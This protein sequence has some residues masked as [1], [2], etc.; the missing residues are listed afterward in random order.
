VACDALFTLFRL[1]VTS[2]RRA[3]V[4]VPCP[5][6]TAANGDPDY[7]ELEAAATALPPAAEVARWDCGG[8]NGVGAA[9]V[10]LA[11]WIVHSA[12]SLRPRVV[13]DDDPARLSIPA[14]AAGRSM[15]Q[16]VLTGVGAAGPPPG[17]SKAPSSIV[18]FHGTAAESMHSVLRNGL[19]C[20]SGSGLMRTGDVFGKGVYLSTDQGVAMSFAAPANVTHWASLKSDDADADADAAAVAVSTASR[21]GGSVAFVA[22]CEVSLSAKVQKAREQFRGKARSGDQ[23]TYLVVEDESDVRVRSILIVGDRDP[24]AISASASSSS[25]SSSSSATSA[26]L[27]ASASASASASGPPATG[28]PGAPLT[29]PQP[30]QTAQR[31]PQQQPGTGRGKR[32]FAWG[33]ALYLVLMLGLSLSRSVTVMRQWRRFRAQVLHM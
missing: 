11:A 25:S 24:A 15:T 6:W 31:A 4:C 14:S 3:T 16:I 20:M 27:A 13:R 18:A 30:V 19:R 32:W 2:R 8:G 33:I 29:Q 17:A 28:S 22:V 26:S 9:V 7:A 12:R 23:G 10:E 1:A 5:Q 21:F